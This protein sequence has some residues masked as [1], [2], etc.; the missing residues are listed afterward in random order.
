MREGIAVHRGKIAAAAAAAAGIASL[1]LPLAAQAL[2]VS[3]TT[4]PANLQ[5]GA[6][7]DVTININFGPANEDV[8]N[9][10]VGLPPGLTG[11]PQA[12]PKCTLAQLNSATP[13]N[14]GCP[15]NTQV[16]SVSVNA[17]ITIAVLP[18]P[19]TVTGKLYNLQPQPGEPARFGIVLQ[20]GN[21]GGML[22]PPG[23]PLDP[24]ILQ[25]GAVL[26]TSDFGLDTVINDIP[27]VTPAPPPLGDLPTHINSQA[28]TLF[29]TAPGTGNAFLRNPTSCTPKV[30]TFTATP[31]PPATGTATATAPAF[32]PTGCGSLDFSPAFSARMGAQGATGPTTRPP[33]TTVIE[34]EATEAGLKK[35]EVFLP[36]VVGSDLGPLTSPCPDAQFQAGTCPASTQVGTAVAASPFLSAPLTGPVHVVEAAGLPDVGLDLRGELPLKL[37]GT[38]AFGAT[39]GVVF[40]NLP[41]IPISNFALTFSANGLVVSNVDLCTAS[42]TFATT[43]TAHS[44]AVQT[45]TT[46]A[47]VDGCGAAP[48]KSTK[49]KAK[50]KKKKKGAKAAAKPKKKKKKAKCKRKKRKKKKGK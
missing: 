25:S 28:I 30:T 27:K 13:G 5:A 20:P 7:S 19:V 46:V 26:R 36:S 41:D 6:N 34:Q 10:T 47:T 42:P 15:A 24:V 32:T 37:K 2:T 49:C 3:G 1:A 11:N 33:V 4:T 48:K 18:V 31:H 23:L 16:G 12:T 43:F 45:G 39:T 29:G 17:S 40:D 14:D 38:F 50:K 8:Q 21:L 9:L 44:G 35:A 22:P